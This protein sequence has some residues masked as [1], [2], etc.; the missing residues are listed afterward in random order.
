MIE[1]QGQQ[2][3]DYAPNLERL[4]S[5]P[6]RRAMIDIPI[7][8]PKSGFRVCDTEARV[9]VSFSVFCGA[10]RGM[11]NF[12]NMSA[13]NEYYWRTEGERK[14]ISCQLWNLRDKIKEVDAFITPAKQEKLCE[15]HPELVFWGLNGQRSLGGKKTET[16]R[17]Q[18]IA[19]LKNRGFSKIEQWL[20]LRFN[21][22]IGR[23]DLI[24]ACVCAIAARDATQKLGGDTDA[25]GLRMEMHY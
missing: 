13:A 10:R 17:Q 7:G 4:L 21:T 14:G 18:R 5:A 1:D 11:W 2:I 16:G 20:N 12:S 23:D 9:K 25:R 8:L 19:I 22:G 24:D 3:F 6:Y 15:T